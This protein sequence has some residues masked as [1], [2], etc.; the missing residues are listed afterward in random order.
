M[1][2]THRS[3][4]EASIDSSG[5]IVWGLA[6]N[7]YQSVTS[8]DFYG[9]TQYLLENP[10]GRWEIGYQP[11]E[12]GSLPRV[13]VES[14]AGNFAN[15]TTGLTCSVIATKDAFA[16]CSHP[17]SETSTA[18]PLALGTDSLCIGRGA[19]ANSDRNTIAG[20][21]AY[22]GIAK[23]DVTL[24]GFQ[25]RCELAR[26][27][28][29]GSEAVVAHPGESVIGSSKTSH[30]SVI[31]VATAP[32][33]G[34]GTYQLKAI[35]STDG[36]AVPTS[37]AALNVDGPYNSYYAEF[38]VRV[39]GTV[40]VRSANGNDLKVFN[41]DYMRQPSGA[42]YSNITALFTGSNAPA[43]TLVVNAS[44]NLEATVP[45]LSDMRV[46]GVL[47]VDKLIFPSV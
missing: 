6:L 32:I 10:A 40:I 39:T 22:S 28:A 13:V 38:W 5:K 25:A 19:Q 24:F 23:P 21:G 41:V 12:D 16:S 36:S 47:R 17:G 7:G 43:I 3:K 27:T 35:E 8:T 9:S 4:F 29:I 37:L 33:S 45:A 2:L 20:I 30:I 14:S 15:G 42:V 34:A 31:P 18:A 1:I 46:S 44:G 26:G 11:V